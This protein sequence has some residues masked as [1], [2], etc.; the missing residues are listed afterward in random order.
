MVVASM[1][2]KK[3]NADKK[4]HNT[5]RFPIFEYEIYTQIFS[6]IC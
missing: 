2:K 1:V 3:S 5:N 6:K 4:I